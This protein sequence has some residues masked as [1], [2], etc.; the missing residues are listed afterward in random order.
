MRLAAG[1][2]GPDTAPTPGTFNFWFSSRSALTPVSGSSTRGS[3]RVFGSQTLASGPTLTLS[4]ADGFPFTTWQGFVEVSDLPFSSRGATLT[5]GD[6]L[7]QSSAPAG[8]D[9]PGREASFLLTGVSLSVGAEESHLH[10]AAGRAKYF[11]APGSDR[12]APEPGVLA[13]RHEGRYRWGWLDLSVTG[14][15][16]ALNVESG[17]EMGDVAVAT[18]G[19]RRRLGGRMVGFVEGLGA[20]SSALAVRTGVQGEAAALDFCASAYHFGSEFP[21]LYPLFRPG[22]S[23]VDASAVWRAAE[24]TTVTGSLNWYE[25][26]IERHRRDVRGTLGI[27]HRLGSNRPFFSLTYGRNET[28]WEAISIAPGIE[29]PH[30]L[31]LTTGWST[32]FELVQLSA[33]HL[34]GGERALSQIWLVA[35]RVVGPSLIVN[36]SAVAERRESNGVSAEVTADFPLRGRYSAI[37]GVGGV[38]REVQAG[39]LVDAYAIGGIRR[40]LAG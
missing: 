34:W 12:D 7:V 20:S 37:T 25:Q 35:R 24:A 26:S 16:D 33:E 15:E 18:V 13:V 1:Q 29:N 5:A 17:E 39:D 21:Y 32:Q 23:G 3:F 27:S 30:R 31:S 4:F 11:S 9:I 36:A 40:E 28:I 14:L 22:E 2:T 6:V 8:L 38:W 19:A 10:L